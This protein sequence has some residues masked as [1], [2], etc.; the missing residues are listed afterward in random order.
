LPSAIQQRL[1]RVQYE[2]PAAVGV[3]IE[4]ARAELAALQEAQVVQMGNRPPRG[5]FHVSDAMD[6]ARGLV[7]YFFGVPNSPV[8]APNMRRFSDLYV[9]LDRR[10]GVSWH[11]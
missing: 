9:A 3:A 8:P 5:G 2:T 1:S 6:D 11:F 4:E 7:E 10:C